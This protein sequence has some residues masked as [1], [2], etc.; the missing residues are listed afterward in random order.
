MQLR[1]CNTGAKH[2][3]LL[4]CVAS[5]HFYKE[6]EPIRAHIPERQ[7]PGLTRGF[8]PRVCYIKGGEPRVKPGVRR[9]EIWAQIANLAVPSWTQIQ[10]SSSFF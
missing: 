9:P 2:T 7:T 1:L 8:T 6:A 4:L 3:L 5:W 10:I